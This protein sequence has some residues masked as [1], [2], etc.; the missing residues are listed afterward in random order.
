MTIET[1]ALKFCQKYGHSDPRDIL[2]VEMAIRDERE[3]CAEIAEKKAEF[4]ADTYAGVCH[5]IASRIREGDES[6]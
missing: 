2:L 1:E 5:E 3:R 6:H 4:L